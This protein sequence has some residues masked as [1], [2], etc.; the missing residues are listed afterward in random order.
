MSFK[1][2]QPADWQQI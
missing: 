2:Q 1:F